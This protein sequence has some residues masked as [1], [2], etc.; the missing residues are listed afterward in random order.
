MGNLGACVGCDQPVEYRQKRSRVGDGWV[1][2][3]CTP[4]QRE[5]AE[6]W[7]RDAAGS[8]LAELGGAA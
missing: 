5:F 4:E 7:Q 6:Q 3:F 8:A 1:H 2:T